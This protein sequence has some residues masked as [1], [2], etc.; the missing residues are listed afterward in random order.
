[1]NYT[2]LM[3]NIKVTKKI[4]YFHGQNKDTHTGAKFTFPSLSKMSVES[5][6]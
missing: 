5:T 4:L 1:M 2:L 6:L 3:K